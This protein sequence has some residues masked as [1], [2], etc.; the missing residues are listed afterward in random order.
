MLIV[1]KARQA[2]L[3]QWLISKMLLNNAVSGG[4]GFV[5]LVGTFGLLDSL[6]E[7]YFNSLSIRQVTL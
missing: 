2:E 7:T 5:P 4:I 3:P 6:I 1:K